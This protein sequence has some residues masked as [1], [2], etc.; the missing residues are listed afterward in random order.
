MDIEK[1]REFRQELI[2]EAFGVSDDKNDDYT[3]G[4]QDALHNFKSVAERRDMHPMDVLMVYKQ[5]HQDA[6]DNFVRT[7]GESESEPIRQRII[8]DINYSVLLL[9]LYNDLQDDEEKPD[10]PKS[11]FN[12]DGWHVK[13]HGDQEPI[14]TY[15]FPEEEDEETARAKA[16]SDYS[17]PEVVVDSETKPII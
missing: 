3:V 10:R 2:D 9:A 6:I 4:S 11:Q 13:L 16:L 14:K 5:K 17:G 7:R 1:Y 12:F 8:D 15:T